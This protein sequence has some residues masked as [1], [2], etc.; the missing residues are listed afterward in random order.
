MHPVIKIEDALTKDAIFIDTR[1]PKEYQEDHLPNAINL[2]ILNNEERAVVGTLYKQTSREKAIEK[3]IELFAPK[4]PQFH[5][6]L[7][8]HRDKLIIVYCWRGGMRSRTVV[9]LFKALGFNL[10]QLQGGHKAYRKYIRNK[11]ENFKLKPKLIVLSGL[12][13]TGKT[14]LLKQFPNSLDLENLAQHRGSLYGGINL[15]PSSQIKFENHLYQTL[16]NLNHYDYLFVEGESRRIGNI[17]IPP[18]LWKAMVNGIHIL[19]TRTI[20]NRVQACIKEYINNNTDEIIN[21]TEKLSR[22]ISKTNQALVIEL[23]KNKEYRKAIK[24][25]LEKYYDPLYQNTLKTR[26]FQHTINN[27]NLQEA[28]KELHQYCEQR[29]DAVEAHED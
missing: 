23:L 29:P 9:A 25:L 2:P 26:T 12:T 10:L 27:D 8:K 21:I 24:I 28:A 17:I 5:E 14:D 11:L 4:L 19:I 3:G 6:E 18:F 16:K 22:I 1:T 7:S 13:C 15:T 20:E